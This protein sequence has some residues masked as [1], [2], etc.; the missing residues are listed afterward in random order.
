M[1]TQKKK[2]ISNFAQR[3]QLKTDKLHHKMK[4]VLEDHNYSFLQILTFKHSFTIMTATF[5]G[6]H[7]T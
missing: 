2:K 5:F 3:T 1:I 6:F 7:F 4:I